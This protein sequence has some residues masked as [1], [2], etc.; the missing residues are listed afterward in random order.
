[1]FKKKKVPKGI[2]LVRMQ[3]LSSTLHFKKMENGKKTIKLDRQVD[4]KN[5]KL[6]K[7]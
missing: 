5:L 1:M 4:Q 6:K 2:T 7:Q 3:Y